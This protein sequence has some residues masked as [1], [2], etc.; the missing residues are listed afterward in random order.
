MGCKMCR[1]SPEGAV[2]SDDKFLSDQLAGFALDVAAGLVAGG[3]LE[4]ADAFLASA[5]A[6]LTK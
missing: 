1:I 5:Q 4:P 3:R 2:V 6:M